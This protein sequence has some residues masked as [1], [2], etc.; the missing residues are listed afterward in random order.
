MSNCTFLYVELYTKKK[1][2]FGLSVIFV[3]RNVG[4]QVDE[5]AQTAGNSFRGYVRLR[6]VERQ[7]RPPAR[8]AALHAQCVH[9]TSRAIAALGNKAVANATDKG[10]VCEVMLSLPKV[11][12]YNIVTRENT[13][14]WCFCSRKRVQLM[15]NK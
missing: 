4:F 2:H 5:F 9:N 3:E 12:I 15:N 7:Y 13:T 6:L 10:L 8:L 14:L 11:W 1:F